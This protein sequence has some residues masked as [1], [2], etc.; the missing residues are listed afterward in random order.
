MWKNMVLMVVVMSI[1]E[2][3]STLYGFA[4]EKRLPFTILYNLQ[5]LE[6]QLS[7]LSLD[8]TSFGS[9]QCKAQVFGQI[10]I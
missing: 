10:S 2:T 5:N 1:R 8:L 4:A 3:D 6:H 9:L 7:T